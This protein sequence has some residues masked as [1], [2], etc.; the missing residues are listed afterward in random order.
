M[1]LKRSYESKV[2]SLIDPSELL[3][4]QRSLRD[5]L[6]CGKVSGEGQRQRELAAEMLLYL[7]EPQACW[8]ASARWLMSVTAADR[9]DAGFSSSRD[10]SYRPTFEFVRA[11][12]M[13]PR[14]LGTAMNARDPGIA[15]VWRSPRVVVFDDV[16]SDRRLGTGVRAALLAAGTRRKLAVALRDATVDVGLVCV[17]A[18]ASDPWRAEECARL[19]SVARH[20]MAPILDAARRFAGAGEPVVRGTDPAHGSDECHGLTPTELRVA[21]LV[22]AG[23]SYKEI[24]RQLGRSVSTVDHHLRSMRD[25]LGVNST[26]KLMHHLMALIPM[27]AAPGVLY[28]GRH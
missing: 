19:D 13:L 9:I 20:V 18:T 28:G 7:D 4:V 22:M 15:A 21:R 27:P 11:D 14:V 2:D 8:E 24:A 16:R 23:C 26:A 25:K 10:I 1:G 3:A 5:R 17:D 6:L 12:V